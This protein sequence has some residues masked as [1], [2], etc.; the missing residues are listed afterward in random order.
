MVDTSLSGISKE[1]RNRLKW[2]VPVANA[3]HPRV[4]NSEDIDLYESYRALRKMLKKAVHY[5][6]AK[7][8]KHL[9]E[10]M[11]VTYSDAALNPPTSSPA[12]TD[13]EKPLREKGLNYL[14]LLEGP[15]EGWR[16]NITKCGRCGLAPNNVQAGD[17][18]SV[19]NGGQVPFVLRKSQGREGAY[20]LIGECFV[21]TIMKGEVFES[22]QRSTTQILRL[23]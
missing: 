12:T 19:F 23:H 3:L 6:G 14:S 10:M 4:A 22:T 9:L 13:E 11:S 1:K 16:F 21:S 18:V 17:L 20:R 15:L 2:E 5:K 7:E 8:K